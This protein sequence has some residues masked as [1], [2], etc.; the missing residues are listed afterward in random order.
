[1]NLAIV[2]LHFMKFIESCLSENSAPGADEIHCEM[3]THLCGAA[4]GTLSKCFN[5]I[6]ILG[7]LREVWEKPLFWN[8]TNLLRPITFTSCLAKSSESVLNIWFA[9]MRSFHTAVV[10][11]W[12]RNRECCRIVVS[13]CMCM[14]GSEVLTLFLVSRRYCEQAAMNCT[15]KTSGFY[16]CTS[17]A[18]VP[19]GQCSFN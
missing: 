3:L 9:F 18:A 15:R 13:E 16:I 2:W 14:A 17:P 12:F 6:W 11:P 5:K 7:K 8:T 19:K 10:R 1:M 4:I